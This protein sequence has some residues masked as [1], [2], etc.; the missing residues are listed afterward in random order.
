[1]TAMDKFLTARDWH[2]NGSE[3]VAQGA[4]FGF[5]IYLKADQMV[6]AGM[7][8]AE[9]DRA[10]GTHNPHDTT[11]RGVLALPGGGRD[12]VAHL[13]ELPAAPEVVAAAMSSAFEVRF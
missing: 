10:T 6:L 7:S 9:L 4:G 5:T 12:L 2:H 1:M 11:G 3:F 8:G 13:F